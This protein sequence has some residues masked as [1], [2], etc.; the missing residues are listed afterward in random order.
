MRIQVVYRFPCDQQCCTVCPCPRLRARRP[1]S[2][3]DVY[4]DAEL[5]G[6]FH[7]G[8]A[9]PG[10]VNRCFSWKV[11]ARLLNE[12]KNYLPY[13][14]MNEKFSV[15]VD[16]EEQRSDGKCLWDW[17]SSGVLRHRRDCCEE[18][19]C[20]HR[21]VETGGTAH[22]EHQAPGSTRL[23]QEAEGDLWARASIV[24]SEKK[25]AGRHPR[26]RIGWFE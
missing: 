9:L 15:C 6:Q 3:R 24:V 8:P 19:A 26:F 16:G 22:G 7:A 10:A 20:A 2:L 21:F 5:L 14:Q 11:S 18:G 4:L 23:G 13:F 17:T 25:W 12:L 1:G